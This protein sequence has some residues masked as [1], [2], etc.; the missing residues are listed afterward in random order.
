MVE[1][2]SPRR[3]ARGERRI[4][5]ILDAAAGVSPGSLFQF[6]G[7]KDEIVRAL[8]ERY[9]VGLGAAHEKAFAAGSAA[10][11]V[12]SVVDR[13]LEPL[14]RFNREHPAFKPLFART[15]MPA[16]L[17]A[18]AAPV[19]EALLAPR[20]PD[21]QADE[22]RRRDRGHQLVKALMPLIATAAPVESE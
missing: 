12:E 16:P 19:H 20:F 5:Q 14:V 10:E 4:A 6:F 11:P 17:Q 2:A 7:N 13:V 1:N 21:A 3:Q 15:D 8:A 9:A 18:A 22:L